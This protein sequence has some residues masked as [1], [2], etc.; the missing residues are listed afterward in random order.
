MTGKE[1]LW[2]KLWRTSGPEEEHSLLA[3]FYNKRP[4][5]K[6]LQHPAEEEEEAGIHP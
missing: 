2:S 5:G 1:E 3:V 6:Q 4:G